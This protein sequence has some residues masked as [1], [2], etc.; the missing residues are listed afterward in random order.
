MADLGTFYESIDLEAIHR[1]VKQQSQEGIN[2]EFKTVGNRRTFG[3]NDRQNLAKAISGFA[4][5]EGGIVVWGI[6][7]TRD[8]EGVDAASE[9][10]PIENVRRAL[11]DLQSNTARATSPIADAVEHKAIR[12]GAEES[13]YLV[14]YVPATHGDPRMAKLGVDRYMKRSGDSFLKMEH[15]EVA[16]MFGRRRRPQLSL[17]FDIQPSGKASGPGGVSYDVDVILGIQNSG[18]GIARFPSIA[19]ATNSPYELHYY[20]LDGNRNTGLPKL[21]SRNLSAS[22]TVFGGD[23][24][25]V[26]HVDSVLEVTKVRTE[27]RESRMAAPDLVVKYRICAQDTVPVEGEQLITGRQLVAVIE[28]SRTASE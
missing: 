4:N 19:L 11:S 28:A 10:Q 12:E 14:T 20:G 17:F 24:N 18:R 3:P 2:L 26:V 16:D 7:A 1:F 22:T 6:R 25:H 5:A 23:A 13:G 21:V 15:F 27:I 9:V 8:H